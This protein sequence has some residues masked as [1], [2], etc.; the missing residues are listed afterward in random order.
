[1]IVLVQLLEE[2]FQ[3]C[4]FIFLFVQ[5][6]GGELLFD[7][8]DPNSSYVSLLLFVYFGRQPHDCSLQ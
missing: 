1:M 3:G 4:F 2:I 5:A 8:V 6:A 7:N